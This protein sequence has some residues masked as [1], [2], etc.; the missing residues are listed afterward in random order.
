MH[1]FYL[2]SLDTVFKFHIIISFIYKS[3]THTNTILNCSSPKSPPPNHTTHPHLQP[4]HHH[5]PIHI[6]N[7]MAN[8]STRI[9][10]PQINYADN[11]K[12]LPVSA[13]IHSLT[14]M[15]RIDLR[16]LT[17]RLPTASTQV[18]AS[19]K[20]QTLTLPIQIQHREVSNL[21]PTKSKY[22]QSTTHV[23]LIK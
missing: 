9:R 13:R 14:S 10:S 3:L 17:P 20:Q 7:Y 16:P 22:P 5:S 8:S 15:T 11:F 23:H 21:P 18:N 19:S 2:V 12:T 6:Q 1:S 4:F